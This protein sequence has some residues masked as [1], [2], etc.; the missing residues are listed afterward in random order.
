MNTDTQDFD[1][2]VLARSERV[3]VLVDFWAPWCGPCKM[4]GPIVERLA[5]AAAGRWV[6]VKIN[7]E[8]Q[9]ELAE[10]F[11][12]RGIPNLKLFH[13]GKVIAE[14]AGALPEPQLSAWLAENLPTPKRE[15]MARAREL[16]LSA[17]SKDAAS[18]LRPLAKE[19]PDDLELAAL[20][21]RA[22]VFSEPNEAVALIEAQAPGAPWEDTLT[23]VKEF[24]RLFLLE[25][26]AA[27]A[28]PESPLRDRYVDGI[29]FLQSEHFSDALRGFI[30]VLEEKPTYDD[31]HAKAVC[32]A[33]FKHLGMR[34]P[35]T[36]EFS[37][38]FSMAVNV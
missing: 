29:R 25:K 15:V 20:T 27:K 3:P 23:M 35:V 13:H 7:T 34:H 6:L 18:L 30:A 14:L 16:L 32:M 31:G 12:I 4:L 10:R 24:A 8:E 1:T 17:K 9:P 38:K 22:L 11:Q 26:S 37:R 21:A 2:Y 36:E 33:V 5:S 19:N 28:L